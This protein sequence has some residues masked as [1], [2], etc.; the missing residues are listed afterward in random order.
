MLAIWY[1]SSRIWKGLPRS[2]RVQVRTIAVM[3]GWFIQFVL[4]GIV[5]YAAQYFYYL[6]QILDLM[7]GAPIQ[8]VSFRTLFWW[9]YAGLAWLFAVWG[10]FRCARMAGA[11]LFGSQLL[12]WLGVEVF[13]MFFWLGSGI[14][15]SWLLDF[16]GAGLLTLAGTMLALHTQRGSRQPGRKPNDN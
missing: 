6:Q 5:L 15:E 16:F 7:E 3:S 11:R 13:A 14:S 8:E 12:Y 9:Q 1:E 4:G 2:E 10:A